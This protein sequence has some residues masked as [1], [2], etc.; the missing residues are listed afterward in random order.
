MSRLVSYRKKKCKN[1]NKI[2]KPTSGKQIYC[3]KCKFYCIDCGKEVSFKQTRCR[4]C[5]Q[6]GEKNN[7]KKDDVRKKLREAQLKP[8]Y[9]NKGGLGCKCPEEKKR[10]MSV[11][12]SGKGNP[13]F[14]KV[15]YGTGRCKWY[16]Y[17]SQIAG[18]VRLQGTYELRMANILDK[19]GW[20]WSKTSDYFK[21]NDG[22]HAYIPDFKI[23]KR[24]NVPCLFYIDTKGWFP[25][26]EQIKIAKVRE[27]NS[28]LLLIIDED[29]LNKYERRV[30]YA[31]GD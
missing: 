6:L 16:D 28:I 3:R 31:L 18:N 2:F 8:G 19:L 11:K 7:A 27:E 24:E 17:F 22:N 25:I 30:N 29:M 10:E 26:Q 23:T 9:I 14:G 4:S 13:N 20:E 21:Y 15:T 5:W 12:Y 1:C